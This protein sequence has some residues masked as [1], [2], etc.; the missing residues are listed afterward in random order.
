MLFDLQYIFEM[1]VSG[2]LFFLLYKSV[3]EARAGYKA[4]RFFLIGSTLASI[5]LPFAKIPVYPVNSVPLTLPLS[6]EIGEFSQQVMEEAEVAAGISIDYSRILAL[7]Y[8]SVLLV[9]LVAFASGIR[10]IYGIRKSANLT[11]YDGYDIAEQESI[12][13]P[14]SFIRTIYM[15]DKTEG[16]EREIIVAH[17][18]S[19]IRHGHSF[20]KLCMTLMNAL[21]W[22]NPFVRMSAKALDEVHEWEADNDVLENGFSW[23]LY[24]TTIFKQLVGYYPEVGGGLKQ[25]L[26]KKRFEMMKKEIKHSG[27]MRLAVCLSIVAGTVFLFGATIKPVQAQQMTQKAVPDSEADNSVVIEFKEDGTLLL[28]GESEFDA[29]DIK[30]GQLV[31]IKADDG[32]SM[33]AITD[34]KAKVL[35][36]IPNLRLKYVSADAFDM[37]LY[38]MQGVQELEFVDG[39]YLLPADGDIEGLI[40]GMDTKLGPPSSKSIKGKMREENNATRYTLIANA[41]RK[42]PKV[43]I[44]INT[45]S[46]TFRRLQ[47]EQYLIS[48]AYSKVRNE[49]S[50]ANFG[51]PYS[52]LDDEQVK[53]T[54]SAIPWSVVEAYEF[55][56][57]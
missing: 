38:E 50:L 34:L 20:E 52:E 56:T 28:N 2:G 9:A 18:K 15:S 40:F 37:S 31:V 42:N 16:Q 5:L 51:K 49:H 32:V 55:Y 57:D 29:A 33:G 46:C 12:K 36:H 53:I 30:E 39:I 17:E 13:S 24:R 45:N 26:T 43:K 8:Y 7:V 47:E 1:L 54:Q 21:F 19:H 48:A 14:F 22:F 11:R 25:S 44:I 10:K 3:L 23:Y 4:C 27:V 41:L 6:I 35:R